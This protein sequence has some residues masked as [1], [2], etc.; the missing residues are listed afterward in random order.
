MRIEMLRAWG[1]GGVTYNVGQVLEEC[2]GGLARI[3]IERGWAKLLPPKDAPPAATDPPTNR[4]ERT[5]RKA[6]ERRKGA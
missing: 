3:L 5:T 2:Q 4:R 6:S 1:S